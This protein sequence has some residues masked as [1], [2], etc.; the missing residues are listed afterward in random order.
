MFLTSKGVTHQTSVPHTPQQNGHAK[1]FNRTILEKAEAMHQYA[2]LPKVFWQATVETA[3]HIYNRQPMCHHKWKTSIELFNG[4]NLM[5]HISECLDVVLMYLAP[6]NNG[7][8][9]C[10]PSQKR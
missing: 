4:K 6:L 8:T 10:L 5:H 3:L 1:R 9:N 7:Q 2:C